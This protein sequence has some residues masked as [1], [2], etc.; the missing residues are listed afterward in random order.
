[1]GGRQHH[2]LKRRGVRRALARLKLGSEQPLVDLMA[3]LQQCIPVLAGDAPADP[4]V[5]GVVDGRFGSQRAAFF[6][7]LLDL[8]RA[9]MNLD[10]GLHAAGDHL[11][12]K[13]S[14]GAAGHAPGEHDRDLVRASERELIRQRALKPRT[15]GSRAIKHPRSEISSWRNARSYP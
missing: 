8:R 2:T 9:V 12:V 10:R 7:V 15:P 11:G 5:A 14:R 3:D 6:E 4:E 1:M 13:P